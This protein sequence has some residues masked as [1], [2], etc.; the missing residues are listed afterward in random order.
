M[1]Q[2]NPYSSPSPEPSVSPQSV[3][4]EPPQSVEFE[5][6]EE[7]FLACNRHINTSL[8][9]VTL[10]IR[11]R[12]KYVFLAGLLSVVIGILVCA[13][14]KELE[15]AGFGIA[16][17]V[18]GISLVLAGFRLPDTAK[19]NAEKISRDMLQNEMAY[20]LDERIRITLSDDG[21]EAADKKGYFLRRWSAIKNVESIDGML[22]IYIKPAE[23]AVVPE[24]AF[25]D[26]QS[27]HGFC[28]LAKQ[29]WQAAQAD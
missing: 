8:P 25:F 26:E 4:L 7:D 22:L 5:L 9:S 10:F 28:E 12:Q 19:K 11:R 1:P 15:R 2:D 20:L 6:S 18:F 17:V 29:L 3:T 14:A 21:F 23:A 27:Y 16:S 13:A 24:R